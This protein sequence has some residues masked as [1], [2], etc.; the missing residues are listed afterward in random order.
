MALVSFSSRP[1]ANTFARVSIATRT[2][3]DSALVSFTPLIVISA[4]SCMSSPRAFEEPKQDYINGPNHGVTLS[5]SLAATAR[6]YPH[7]VRHTVPIPDL[8]DQGNT[9][10][11]TNQRPFLFTH[12]LV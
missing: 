9:L 7:R 1:S 12:V 6:L 3:I 8:D 5:S 2:V 11:M 4:S 10:C